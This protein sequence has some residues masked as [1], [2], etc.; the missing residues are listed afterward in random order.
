MAIT[1][2]GINGTDAEQLLLNSKAGFNNDERDINAESYLLGFAAFGLPEK[3]YPEWQ[4]F[5]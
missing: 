2:L 4:K 5:I 1:A 3:I